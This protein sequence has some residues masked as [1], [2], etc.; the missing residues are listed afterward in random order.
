VRV[1]A[2]V[3][4]VVLA[5]PAVLVVQQAEPVVLVQQAEPAEPVARN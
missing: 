5:R 1:P 4:P 3:V 2:Q